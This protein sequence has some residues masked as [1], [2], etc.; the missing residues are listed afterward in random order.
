MQNIYN[1]R[2]RYVCFSFQSTAQM[3]YWNYPNGWETVIAYLNSRGYD[4]YCIDKHP[5]FG[6]AAVKED[7]AKGIKAKKQHMNFMPKNAKDKTG[8]SVKDLMYILAGCEFFIGVSSGLS[9]L[10][11]AMKKPVFLIS[12][13]TKPEFEFTTNCIRIYNPTVCNGCLND[14]S[15]QFDKGDWLA[16]PN[17]K[18]TDRQFECSKAIPPKIVIDAINSYLQ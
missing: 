12:G 5:I 10:A 15:I 13:I 17:H 6:Q 14:P 8:K 4:V 11:W 7:P 3:K 1:L 16:C 9:W 18:G 2:K